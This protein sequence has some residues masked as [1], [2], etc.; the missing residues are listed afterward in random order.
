[1]TLAGPVTLTVAVEYSWVRSK[2]PLASLTVQPAVQP[3]PS[4]V[5]VTLMLRLIASL[6]ARERLAK[7]SKLIVFTCCVR[8]MLFI[9]GT[10]KAERMAMMSTTIIIST[11][12][13]PACQRMW[14]VLMSSPARQ[15]A[16][17]LRAVVV[18]RE[19]FALRA[20][21]GHLLADRRRGDGEGRR[22]P[23]GDRHGE[24]IEVGELGGRRL[25]EREEIGRVRAR[26]QEV[27]LLQVG[28]V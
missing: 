23:R 15:A 20:P 1:M 25:A 16:A 21:G 17:G 13:K 5:M 22:R 10:A 6:R 4:G 2:L 19:V 26:I 11:I 8:I 28:D 7:M 3:P 24:R 14:R 27:L 12:V 18:E 9:E